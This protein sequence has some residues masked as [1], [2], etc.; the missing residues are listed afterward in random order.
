MRLAVVLY[1]CA[2]LAACTGNLPPTETPT[3]VQ[4]QPA[5]PERSAWPSPA[6][7]VSGGLT[8]LMAFF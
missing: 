8:A 4:A 6:A 3:A 7:L 1:V 2:G 5:P